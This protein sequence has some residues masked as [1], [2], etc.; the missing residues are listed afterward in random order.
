MPLPL[1]LHTKAIVGPLV[2]AGAAFVSVFFAWWN[3]RMVK[4]S[5]NRSIYVD[6]NKLLIEIDKLLVADPVLWCLYDDGPLRDEKGIYLPN[7]PTQRA[8]LRAFAHLHLNM[9]EIILS[10]VPKRGVWKRN[11]SNVWYD[12]FNDTLNRSPM[13]RDILDEPLSKILWSNTMHKEHEQWKEKRTREAIAAVPPL[14]K[15][16][17]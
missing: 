13:I 8:K 1:G 14:A 6:G 2:S 16:E 5:A 9:F 7:D 4:R 11:A 17:K 15:A 12:Y 3:V 10:E